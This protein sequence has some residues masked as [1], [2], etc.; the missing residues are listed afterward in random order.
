MS[1]PPEIESGNQEYKLRIT[2]KSNDR[3][4][5]LASQL[6]WRLQEG[7][8]NAEYF[9]GVADDGTIPGINYYDYIA[10]LKN[11]IKMTKII[12]AKILKKDKIIVSE[13][14][15]YY[16][17]K[18]TSDVLDTK[19][20][21][22]L[23][24]GPSNSGKST[25]IGNLS[26]RISDDGN[27]KSRKYVFNHK[28]EIYSGETSSVSI[29]NLVLKQENN[30][31]NINLID[32]PGNSKYVKTMITAINKYLP[33][34]IF[35]VLD[36]LEIDINSLKFYLEI[37]KYYKYPFQI[38]LTKKDKYENLH[39]NYL[40]KNILNICNKDYNENNIKKVP[41]IE[42][43]NINNL[44]YRR[45]INSIQKSSDKINLNNINN[46]DIQICDV[47]NIPN[48]PKIYT[49]LTFNNINIRDKKVLISSDKKFH[50]NFNSIFF[51][52][53]PKE[54]ISKGHLITFT[55]NN[56]I[57]ID[58][59]S[60]LIIASN[61]I[62]EYHK[63]K[64]KCVKQIIGSQ[65]ICIYNNQYKVIK[66]DYK[67]NNEYELSTLDKTKFINLAKKIVIKINEQIYLTNL[68]E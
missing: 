9:I 3:I 8:G 6:K 7:Q 21:R 68:I 24:I 55:L 50:I 28:H 66:I 65:G 49:G 53:K 36:P 1:L 47:L 46:I 22:I 35:L 31:L 5:Q 29:N 56:E 60:D 10:S 13:N 58:N 45:L 62:N 48:F 54:T 37:L 39:K 27:G 40:L 14:I 57:D 15:C 59:K 43:N 33:D 2:N 18:I 16:I 34:C 26:K 30:K 19:S 4:E 44:G 12:E 25:I 23:F 38:I 41:Y 67:N 63:I 52:D 61:T 32:T 20:I 17:I 42:V 11:L 64:V 51:L